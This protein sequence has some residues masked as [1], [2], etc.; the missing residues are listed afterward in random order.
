M[1]APVTIG[2]AAAVNNPLSR[3]QLNSVRNFDV[4]KIAD[5]QLLSNMLKTRPTLLDSQT[6]VAFNNSTMFSGNVLAQLFAFKT[7][8]I[9]TTAYDWPLET[10]NQR[11][12]TIIGVPDSLPKQCGKGK[13]PFTLKLDRYAFGANAIV[14]AGDDR[15]T[16]FT[17]F[18]PVP[19]SDGSGF[20]FTFQI[21]SD[22]GEA[23]IDSDYLQPGKFLSRGWSEYSEISNRGDGIEF[24]SGIMLRNYMSIAR[25]SLDVTRVLHQ[26]DQMM[27]MPIINPRT[28]EKAMDVVGPKLQWQLLYEM[29]K[30]EERMGWDSE[31]KFL[32]VDPKTNKPVY[33]G[34]GIKQQIAGSNNFE[35]SGRLSYKYLTRI[36]EQLTPLRDGASGKFRIILGSGRRGVSDFDE[37]VERRA[38]EKGV[39]ITLKDVITNGDPSAMVLSGFWKGI[40]MM[41]GEVEVFCKHVPLFDDPAWNQRRDSNGDLLSSRD[42]IIMNVGEGGG[43]GIPNVSRIVMDGGDADGAL[44]WYV[45]GSIDPYSKTGVSARA[46]ASG[47]DGYTMHTLLHS[48]FRLGDP[49][50]AA[51]IRMAR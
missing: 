50:A 31:P 36:V 20:L 25:K 24:G 39:V 18:D 38:Q 11:R 51:I 46:A 14:R 5:S 43:D 42:M 35:R 30:D 41:G 34:A 23:Y 48:S 8:S 1:P 17:L 32:M 15:T 4:Q 49:S 9:K 13:K 40:E 44:G 28:G 7:Q 27:S 45:P 29:K 16:F 6:S 19:E 37:M 22:D 33:S 10:A 2:G 3:L 12:I 26:S 21:N 47:A